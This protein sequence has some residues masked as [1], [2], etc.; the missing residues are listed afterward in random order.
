MDLA[1]GLAQ[2]GIEVV[3]AVIGPPPD[4]PQQAAARRIKGLVLCETGLPLDWTARTSEEVADASRALADLSRTTSAA[5][6][7]LHSPALASEP[8]FPCPVVASIH[9]CLATWWQAVKGSSPLP[10][11]F[12]WRIA[13]TGAGLRRASV[14][15]APSHAFA[16]A[17]GSA[18]GTTPPIVVHNGRAGEPAAP[19]LKRDAFAFTAGRLWDEGKNVAAIDRAAARLDI[20]IHAAGPLTGPGGARATFSH[21][22]TLGPLDAA[23]TAAHMRR[24]PVYVSS[25]RYEP[26][27]LSVL[28]AASNGAALVLSGIPVFRELWSDAAIFT[29]PDDD[30]DI[31]A[32]IDTLL[33]DEP[34]RAR[35]A[36]AARERA[37]RFGAEA[38]TERMLAIYG[39]AAAS[40]EEGERA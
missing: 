29:E 11:D 39:N 24:A 28:E 12:R 20:P 16:L 10:D 7:H 19:A 21:L 17:V 4:G 25:A 5:I 13:Q 27:G 15:T 9:S 6:A 3:L 38:M 14:T 18:Y 32:S 35:L 34:L 1:Q 22:R 8:G 23:A 33:N 36:A 26:F 2:R 40:H 31:A 30:L 37:R